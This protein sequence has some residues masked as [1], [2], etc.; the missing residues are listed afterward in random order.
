MKRSAFEELMIWKSNP[1][2]KPLVI[3]GARQVGK[4]WLMKAFGAE[5]FKSTAYINFDNN[6][7][8]KAV[9]EGDFSIPRLIAALQVECG[10]TIRPHETLI[11]F[12]EI[13]EAPRA[14]TSLKYFCENTPEY[15]IIAAGSLLGVGSHKDV[16]FPVGKVEFLNLYPMSFSEFLAAS[17]N[18]EMVH[19]LKSR[20]WTLITALKSK[21]IELLRQ[22]YFIGGMPEAVQSFIRHNDFSKVRSIQLRLLTAYDQDFSKHAPAKIVPRIRMVWNS[23]PSQ[24]AKENRKF[25]YGSIRSGSRAKEFELAIQWLQDCGL[26]Y[27]VERVSK[28]EMPLSAYSSSG[29]KM[30]M[31]DVGLL[32]AKSGLDVK[33]ILEGTRIFTEF[34]GALTEQYVQQQLRTESSISPHYWSAERGDAEIDFIFQCGM[35]IIPL[36]VKAEENLRAKSLI[37]YR[38]KFKP[39]ISIRTSM[40]DYR[41]ESWL[42]NL[43]LYG[44]GQI[45][46]ICSGDRANP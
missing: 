22:Y 14:L 20:D 40:S 35:D 46:A 4:T 24:L 10:H 3:R 44:I 32:A 6:D 36:E 21:Y 13:Q 27:Q 19:V 9:F 18:E 39:N 37:T 29:F 1:E 34:K 11:L 45:S 23:I 2:R 17:G 42:I 33:T 28:P 5:A 8:M 15:P 12:D 31:V 7:A 25:V 43:P 41:R 38:E 26:I 30:F 16:S